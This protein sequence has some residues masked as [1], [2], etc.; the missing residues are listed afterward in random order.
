MRKKGNFAKCCQTKGA[1]N[2][3][4]SRK[5]TKAP[6]Q[7]IQRIDE[8]EDSNGSMIEEDKIVLTIEG[9]EN[10]QFFMSGKINGKQFKT[11]VDS[12]SPVTIFE[13][14]EIKRIMKR[15]SLFIRQLP[16]D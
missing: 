2:F 8:W 16:E 11:M 3:A 9:G 5:V 7:S 15:K 4:K 1:G 6:A 10:G 14:Q 12:S 13:I